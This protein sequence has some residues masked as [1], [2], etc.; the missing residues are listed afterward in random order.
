MTPAHSPPPPALEGCERQPHESPS[1]RASDIAAALSGVA[2]I[3][4]AALPGDARMAPRISL[5]LTCYQLARTIA[6]HTRL[7]PLFQHIPS[8]NVVTVDTRTGEI[9]V[10]TPRRFTTWLEPLV[11]FTKLRRDSE[12]VASLHVET[13]SVILHADV[14]LDALRPLK[15]VHS[16]RLPAWAN[17]ERTAVKLMDPG[18]DEDTQSFTVDTLPFDKDMAPDAARD[19]LMEAFAEF[20]FAR[21]ENEPDQPLHENRSFAVQIASMLALYCRPLLLGYLQPAVA[22]QANQPGSGKTLLLRMAIA[23]VFGSAAI[24]SAPRCDQELGKLLTAAAVEGIPYIVM[25]NL[26]GFFA[27]EQLDSFLT[28]PRRQGRRLGKSEMLEADNTANIF[29]TGNGLRISEDLARRFLLCDLWFAGD[30]RTRPVKKPVEEDRIA[31]SGTRTTFLAALWALVQYWSNM[32]CPRTTGARLATFESFSAVIGGIVTTARFADPIASPE[33]RL[34]E[35]QQAW[36]TLI[37][38]L[39]ESVEDGGGREYNLDEVMEAAND[40]DLLEIL[41][42]GARNPKVSLGMSLKQFRGRQFT[43][44]KG[45]PFEFGR[46]KA[47]AGARYK[48]RILP[49]PE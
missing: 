33:V 31:S 25:D 10:M 34:D 43:D 23:P 6:Q 11:T 13:A 36:Q 7:E 8:G 17:P 9:R 41:V 44:S 3:T 24:Q 16:V 39:A 19:F 21:P 30:I 18:Y 22:Y 15:T 27:S 38:S 1:S 37:T 47:D 14:F 4:G 12:M 29:I 28:S 20:P 5:H 45:R 2:P 42:G 48:V 32:G 49:P 26:S 46:R 40:A 35:K